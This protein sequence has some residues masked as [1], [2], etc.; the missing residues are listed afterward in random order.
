MTDLS[1]YRIL[2]VDD[3]RDSREF[4]SAILADAGAKIIEAASGDEAL[5][6]VRSEKPDLVTLDLEMP[7]IDGSDVFEEMRRDPALQSIPIFIVSGHPELRRLIYQKTLPPPEGFL[8]KPVEPRRL[9]LSVRKILA[10][11]HKSGGS[12]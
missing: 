7:G 6:L 5:R 2:V 12:E 4:I 11:S 10:L 9:L 3:E 8:D 1:R